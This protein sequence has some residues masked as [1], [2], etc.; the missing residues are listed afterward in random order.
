MAGGD[1]EAQRMELRRRL[2]W[3]IDSMAASPRELR[4]KLNQALSV[5]QRS[6]CQ[7]SWR[8]FCSICG[9]R[10][11]RVEGPLQL[12]SHCGL[13]HLHELLEYRCGLPQMDP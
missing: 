11:E 3:T 6:H 7:L 9:M 2:Q 13:H 5:S 4:R 8:A 12:A 1:A 10:F